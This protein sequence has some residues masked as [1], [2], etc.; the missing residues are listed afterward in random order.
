[1]KA[2][3]IIV[4]FLF[5]ACSDSTNV[6]PFENPGIFV[7]TDSIEYNRGSN[8]PANIKVTLSD[9]TDSTLYIYYICRS[10][11][12]IE[13]KQDTNWVQFWGPDCP[14]LYGISI[15]NIEEHLWTDEVDISNAGDFRIALPISRDSSFF[16]YVNMR[17]IYSNEFTVN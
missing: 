7:S 11:F 14:A 15:W 10:L 3:I 16:G 13:K 12:Y 1:M 6:E 2:A 17:F 4:G 8:S 5:F 9:N